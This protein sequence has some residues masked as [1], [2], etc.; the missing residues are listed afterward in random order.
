M[1]AVRKGSTLC[2]VFAMQPVYS[3]RTDAPVRVLVVLHPTACEC[4]QCAQRWTNR[5]PKLPERTLA[6]WMGE[7]DEPP[8]GWRVPPVSAL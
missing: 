4:D 8:A 2:G 5:G 6:M 3:A 7:D 1:H